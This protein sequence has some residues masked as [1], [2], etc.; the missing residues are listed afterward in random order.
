LSVSQA[1]IIQLDA[2][3]SAAALSAIAEHNFSGQHHKPSKNF[4]KTIE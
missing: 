3:I 4:L 1:R 2:E